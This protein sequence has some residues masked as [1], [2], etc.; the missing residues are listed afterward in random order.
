MKPVIL[1]VLIM[2]F[3]VNSSSADELDHLLRNRIEFYNLKPIPKLPANPN[4]PLVELGEMLFSE[5]LISGNRRMSCKTCHDPATSTTDGLPLSQ[6]EDGKNIL[7]RNAP[8]LFNVGLSTRH[9]MFWDGR[10]KLDPKTKILTTPEEAL[11]GPDPKA[12]EIVAQLKSALAAQAIFPM[13]SHNEMMGEKGENE[14]ADAENNL[15]AWDRI[16]ERLKKENPT[17][18]PTKNYVKLFLKAYPETSEEK[19]N[20]GHAGEAIAAFQ[21]EE[22]QSN[23]SPFQ[24]YLRGDNHAMTLSQKRGF[25]V[26]MGRGNCIDCHQGSELGRGD[27]FASIAI[28]QWGAAP[29]VLDKGQGDV[30]KDIK[31]NFFYRV[32]SLVN[33]KLTAPY[34]HNGAYRTLSEV[35][36][37]Y[38]NV[39][40]TLVGF[41]IS[42]E[43][44]DEIPVKVSVAN[45][46][47]ILDDI[48]LSSQSGLF[49]ELRNKLRLL[50]REKRYLEIF[51]KEALADPKWNR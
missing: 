3:W 28:P 13:V 11:N 1:S 31:R 20:I 22:F 30:L 37:H 19:I 16:I 42:K 45:Q 8:G 32:P 38:D 39:S 21:R 41:K 7:A 35:I 47:P 9:F 18:D 34:M 17:I 40:G 33:V 23:D 44:Q 5:K 10:V 43:R 14:I 4:R 15:E 49:P 2:I 25:A 24:R 6:S 26:F 36:E 12:P 27:L 29:F 51:L 48:W 46:Q 50:D